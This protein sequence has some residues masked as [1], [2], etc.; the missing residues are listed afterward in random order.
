MRNVQSQQDDIPYFPLERF[1]KAVA[2]K[3]KAGLGTVTSLIFKAPTKSIEF[4]LIISASQ[5][6]EAEDFLEQR[7]VSSGRVSIT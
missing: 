1:T 6:Q 2:A 7:E 5:Y 4:G 3:D